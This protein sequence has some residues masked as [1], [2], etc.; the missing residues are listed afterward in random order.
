MT[1][2]RTETRTIEYQGSWLQASAK[3]IARK[4]TDPKTGHLYPVM[5]EMRIDVREDV[6][7]NGPRRNPDIPAVFVMSG[8]PEQLKSALAE[9]D[10]MVSAVLEDAK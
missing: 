4:G 3:V 6:K 9:A 1:F 10:R 7:G 2:E 8:T 5:V